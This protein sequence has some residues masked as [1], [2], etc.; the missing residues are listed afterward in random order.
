MVVVV[1]VVVAVVVTVVLVVTLVC[2]PAFGAH[3][4]TQP[5]TNLLPTK[6]CTPQSVRTKL[7]LEQFTSFLTVWIGL[8]GTK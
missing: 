2:F 5:S 7:E 4:H 3:F 6:S 8:T 1:V